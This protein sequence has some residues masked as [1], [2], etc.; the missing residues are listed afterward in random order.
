M[1]SCKFPSRSF[2]IKNVR[3]Q[4]L[5]VGD[6]IQLIQEKAVDTVLLVK[7]RPIWKGLKQK[8]I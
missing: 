6:G 3:H 8:L 2:S 5:S 1:H 7:R 4:F